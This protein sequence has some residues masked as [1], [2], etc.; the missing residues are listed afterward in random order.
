M[1]PGLV[2]KTVVITGASSGIGRAASIAFGRRGANVVIAARNMDR[3]DESAAEVEKTGSQCLV[4]PTDVTQTDQVQKLIDASVERFGRIDVLVNNAGR[5]ML[6]EFLETPIEKARELF[7]VNFF[8]AAVVMHSALRAMKTQGEGTIINVASTAGVLPMA[9]MS[10]YNATKAALISLSESVNIEYMGKGIK[11]VAFCPH[12]TQTDFTTGMQDSGRYKKPVILG[13]PIH[14]G[15]AIE[16]AIRILSLTLGPPFN[17]VPAEWV[18]EQ[19]VQTALKPKP[20]VVLSGFIR[21]GQMAKLLL[22][23]WFYSVVRRSRDLMD[24]ENPPPG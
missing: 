8:A 20:V 24:L 2:G 21:R 22:P 12:V 4:V 5:G 14:C 3:L 16:R 6:G 19:L 7:E 9:Y 11:V 1:T 23:P 15:L 13:H 17:P 10:V 18:A